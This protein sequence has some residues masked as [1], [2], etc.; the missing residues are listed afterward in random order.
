MNFKQRRRQNF[1]SQRRC[2]KFSIRKEVVYDRK[3]NYKWQQMLSRRANSAV[4]VD[5]TQGADHYG[6]NSEYYYKQH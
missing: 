1:A 2:V 6:G 3:Q 4:D 5:G